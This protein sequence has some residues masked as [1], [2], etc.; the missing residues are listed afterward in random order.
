M[1]EEKHSRGDSNGS[2]EVKNKQPD[3]PEC[4]TFFI[5]VHSGNCTKHPKRKKRQQGSLKG[6]PAGDFTLEGWHLTIVSLSAIHPHAFLSKPIRSQG[7]TREAFTAALCSS[8]MIITSTSSQTITRKCE[9][10]T[11]CELQPPHLEK[12]HTF[13]WQ[14]MTTRST[15]L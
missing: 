8:F 4:Y 13:L 15:R 12:H 6:D 7:K 11:S 14:D 1:K 10:W 9:S 2:P 5:Y 3:Q